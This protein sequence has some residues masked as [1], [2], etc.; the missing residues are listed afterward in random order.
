MVNLIE[1]RLNEND[2]ED[3][4][5]L[6]AKERAVVSYGSKNGKLCYIGGDG[7]GHLGL[8]S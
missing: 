6:E 7:F 4:S 5:G 1:C 8:Q 2:M 3:A